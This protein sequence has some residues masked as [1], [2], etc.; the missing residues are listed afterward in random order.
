[1]ALAD[2]FQE[3]LDSLPADWTDIVCD[4]RIADE[5]RYVDA[6][7]LLTQI[8]AQPYSKADWHF[9][10]NVAHASATPPPRRPSR[11][12]SR[13]STRGD[14]RR[15][16]RPRRPRGPRRGRADVGPAGVR[17]A[18]VPGAALAL[19]PQLAGRR[20]EPRRLAGSSTIPCSTSQS[21]QRVEHRAGRAPARG[22][23]VG[24]E[25]RA[26]WAVLLGAVEARDRGDQVVERRPPGR[27][28]PSVVAVRR[29]PPTDVVDQ[30]GFPGERLGRRRQRP[31]RGSAARRSRRPGTRGSGRPARAGDAL[32]VPERGRRVDACRRRARRPRRSRSS[33]ASTRVRVGAAGLEHRVEHGVVGG[34][35]GDA[36]RAALEVAR[37]CGPR[38][39]RRRSRRPAAAGRSRRRRPG[40]ARA[41]GRSRGRGCRGSRTRPGPPRAA[42]ARRSTPTARGPSGRPRRRRRRRR[43]APR[44]CRRGRRSGWKSSTRVA[45]SEAPGSAPSSAAGRKASAREDGRQR[46]DDPSHLRGELSGRR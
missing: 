40:R 29:S 24:V 9:R 5:D 44:R 38:R 1:M 42:S 16:D 7:V 37:A 21:A 13:C 35:A 34:Q 41:R 18:R 45:S 36:D 10:I 46:R 31:A 14:R 27:R 12:P 8:N 6:A 20:E 22:E 43:R 39:G 32:R 17:P 30:L 4:L 11:G 33:P 3:L 26:S 2:D 25:Q 19:R 28:R 15:A 23:R